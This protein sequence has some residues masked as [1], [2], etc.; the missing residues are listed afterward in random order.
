MN[1]LLIPN[2]RKEH[3]KEI[4]V[5]VVG[6]LSQ[7]PV[8]LLM[9]EHLRPE[10]EG[11]SV[12]FVPLEE[13]GLSVDFIIAIGGDGTIIGSSRYATAFHAPILGVNVGRLGF[14]ASVEPGQLSLLKRLTT[15]EYT[16]DKRMLLDVAVLEKGGALREQYLALNDAVFSKGAISRMIELDVRHEDTLVGVYRADGIIFSTPTGSTAYSL[17]TGGPI[18]DPDVSAI[19]M[20]PISPHLAFSR[21]IVF[22]DSKVLRIS[23]NTENINPI[24]LTIDG[25]ITLPIAADDVVVIQKAKAFVSLVNFDHRD[26]IEV[27]NEKIVGKR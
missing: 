4:T 25:Q 11:L 19:T 18:I 14:L 2:L 17:S 7:C 6:I 26:F 12:Q 13:E 22:S 1:I 24:Y 21:A 16:L 15:R 27:L 5:Q 9:E 3:A 10:F 20:T 8:S 23:A